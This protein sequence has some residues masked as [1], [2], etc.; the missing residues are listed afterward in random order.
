MLFLAYFMLNLAYFT[1][2]IS[3]NLL[4]FSVILLNYW[5]TTP[6]FRAKYAKNSILATVFRFTGILVIFDYF[7]QFWLKTGVVD[8]FGLK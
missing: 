5:S 1:G 3:V 7:S 8:W 2:K 6:V 4:I